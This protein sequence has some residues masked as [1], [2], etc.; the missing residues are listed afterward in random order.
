MPE[1]V[2]LTG[3]MV[4]LHTHILPGLDDGAS[5]WEVALA[6]AREAA[7]DGIDTIVATPHVYEP[8]PGTSP[9]AIA[10]KVMQLQ[11]LVDKAGIP[12]RVLPGSE[13]HLSLALPDELRNGRLTTVADGGR[14]LLVELP[15]GS[16]PIYTG[17][18]LFQLQVAGVTPIV[19]HPERNES[20]R[21]NPELLA[22][23]VRRGCLTQV[24]GGSLRGHFG[25]PAERSACLLVRMGL[26]HVMA[27]DGH[28]L[29]RRRVRLNAARRVAAG[30]AGEAGAKA[31]TESRPRLIV[32]GSSVEDLLQA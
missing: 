9:Q 17:E 10:A 16:L 29:E 6:M 20:I 28:A 5:N 22:E 25:E 1:K 32:E 21:R 26:A 15:F 18:V 31:M 19:A 14:Y 3:G 11:Q 4:D 8:L 7:Q 13:V 2:V 12:V 23:L 27:S 24:T 30:L